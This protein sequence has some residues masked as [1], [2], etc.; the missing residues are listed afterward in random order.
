LTTLAEELC[1]RNNVAFAQTFRYQFVVAPEQLSLPEFETEQFGRQWVHIG[2]KLARATLTDRNGIIFGM[3]LGVAVDHDGR[4]PQEALATDFDSAA[5][6]ART[7]FERYLARLA[8][9]YCTITML[10]DETNFHCDPVGMIGAVY[11][12]E[13]GRIAASPFLCIDRE[14]TPNPLYDHDEI[15]NG[16]ASYGFSHTCDTGVFR[17]NANHRMN[18]NSLSSVRFWPFAQDHFAIEANSLAAIYDEMILAGHNVI[19]RMITLGETALPLTGGNDSRILLALAGNRGREDIHQRFSHINNYANRRDSGIAKKLCNTKGLAHE[20]HDRKLSDVP[21]HVKKLASRRYQ[22]ASG[23]MATV[24]KEIANGLF[25]SVRE[26]AIVMRGHQT[27]IM[28]GQ[29]LNSS[30]PHA[31]KR[32]GWQIKTMNLVAQDAFG[33]EVVERFLPEFQR[34]YYDLPPNALE[35]SADFIFLETLVPAALGTLFPGQDHAFYLSPF[36]S[37]RLIQISMQPD[38]AYRRSNATTTDLLLR[39]DPDLA[40]VPFSYELPADL[41]DTTETQSKRHARVGKGLE[42]YLKLFG[43]PAP[44]TLD[45]LIK[46]AIAP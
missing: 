13:T 34:Y 3:C 14:V 31:W 1:T 2:P 41:K 7:A 46:R 11:A 25:A 5:P 4:L 27:N 19:E 45:L 44:T 24:P 21:R 16:A 37:R 36:N 28:R 8:G 6:E 43:A 38:T 15:R 26:G 32:P 35:R 23:T 22:I 42:R 17:M 30:D 33:P 40:F 10:D 12:P 9:R 29:Y 18:L 39:A 20:A